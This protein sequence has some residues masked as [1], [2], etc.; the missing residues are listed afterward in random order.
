M[1]KLVF[2]AC[3]ML[4]G[5]VAMAGDVETQQT[6]TVG[7][8]AVEKVVT[9]L[10]FDGD[11]VILTFDDNTQQRADMAL[12]NIAFGYTA[13]AISAPETARASDGSRQVYSLGGQYLGTT[14]SGLQRGIYVI[15]G[16][17]FVIK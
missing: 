17:K 12:V 13:T 5:A 9:R 10:A 4:S 1:K 6:V 7:D 11:E 8:A 2:S 14:T 16:K 3:L 15:N